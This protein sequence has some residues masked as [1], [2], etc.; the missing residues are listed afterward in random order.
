MAPATGASHHIRMGI[1][2][3]SAYAD[4][5]PMLPTYRHRELPAAEDIS[6]TRVQGLISVLRHTGFWGLFRDLRDFA[7]GL[8]LGWTLST[9]VK[10]EGCDAAYVRA[11]QLQ[12]VAFFLRF[13]GIKVFLE[14]N[15]LLFE[16]RRHHLRSW[17]SFTYE[18]FERVLLQSVTHV[19]FVGSYGRYWKLRKPNWTEVE[20]GIEENFEFNE[21]RAARCGA[22]LRIVMV[23][24]L[25]PHH[26]AQLLTEALLLLEKTQRDT[27]EV[28]LIGTGFEVLIEQISPLC[29][30]H[31]HGFLNRKSI[32][33]VLCKM[34]VGLIP[35]GPQFSS[36]MK[37][38]DYAASGCLVL[39]PDVVHLRNFY[40]GKGIRLFKRG[41]SS[42]L[43]A[44]LNSLLSGDADRLQMAQLLQGFVK[45]NLTWR[46]IFQRKWT[47]MAVHLGLGQKSE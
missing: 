19:F 37:L 35:D 7:Q 32:S 41:S 47:V 29:E 44:A 25:M 3:L 9:A 2:Q 43:A 34:D 5:I 12:T 27:I 21:P 28:H 31:D 15:G 30:I 11:Q 36:Q 10:K 26:R 18:P 6:C 42:S 23:A 13:R 39:A 20:N 45:A 38:L 8:R 4:V 40:E 17:L 14:V 24:R 1:E 22:P 46:S 16:T 33:D